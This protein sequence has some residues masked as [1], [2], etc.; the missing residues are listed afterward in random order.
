MVFHI[1]IFRTEFLEEACSASLGSSVVLSDDTP[2]KVLNSSHRHSILHS[3]STSY[4]HIEDRTVSIAQSTSS[5]TD[6]A[7]GAK[8]SP[9][10]SSGCNLGSLDNNNEHYSSSSTDAPLHLEKTKL[11]GKSTSKGES[12]SSF[13]AIIRSLTRTKESIGR[14]TR[15]A[16]DCAKLGFA[17]KVDFSYNAER[18]LAPKFF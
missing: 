12:L 13:Q 17:T 7:D 8:A 16:I 1:C 3:A 10:S 9:P 14:A 6:G 2:T 4:D 5:L 11:A 15:I 18:F